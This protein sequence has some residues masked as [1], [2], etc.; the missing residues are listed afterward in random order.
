MSIPRQPIPGFDYL[1]EQGEDGKWTVSLT[2]DTGEVVWQ[3]G[4]YKV[5]RRGRASALQWLRDSHG[6]TLTGGQSEQR[7]RSGW[8][9]PKKNQP[10]DES[11][12]M[13]HLARD[14]ERRAVLAESRAVALREQ[15]DKLEMEAK[16]LRAAGEVLNG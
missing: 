5:E 6:I 13:S 3:R 9:A 7:S 8:K 2:D 10:R 12:D 16:K 15:A 1:A 11:P 4:G 14:L